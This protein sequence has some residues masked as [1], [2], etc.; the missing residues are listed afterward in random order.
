MKQY[1]SVVIGGGPAGITAALY[2]LRS[3]AKTALV[4]KL[5]PGGQVLMTEEV[6]NYPGFPTGVKGYELADIFAAHLDAYPLDRFGDEVKIIEHVPYKNRI[7][8]GEE[9]IEAKT[10]IVCSGASYRKLGLPREKELTGRGVSYCA[11]CDGNFYR[12]QEVAVI[13][14]GNSALEEALYLTKLVSKVYLVHRRCEFRGDRIYQEK[15]LLNDKIEVMYDT[16]VAAFVGESDVTGLLLENCKTGEQS[17]LTVNGVFIFVGMEPSASY[18]PKGVARD[19]G[20]FIITD[21]EMHTNLPG[22]FAAGDI[23]SKMCRQVATAVG[24]GATAAHAS[25]LFMEHAHE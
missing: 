3:G 5:S 9:W 23:R 22:I 2:L 14:G 8:V 7:L 6:E 12:G 17:T 20:G 24:D 11:L 4:E 18:L 25:F 19:A 21:T 1:D 10:V 15:V 13:G 16:V